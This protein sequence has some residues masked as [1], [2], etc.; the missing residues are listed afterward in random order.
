MNDAG[1]RIHTIWVAMVTLLLLMGCAAGQKNRTAEVPKWIS[2]LPVDGQYFYAIGISGRTR[3]V[4]DAWTQAANRARAELGRTIVSHVSSKDLIVSTTRGEYS[5]QL[6]DILSDTELNYTE[7]VKRWYDQY[8]NY[9]PPDHYY[10][11][12]RMS[13][14]TAATVLKS[15]N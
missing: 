10:V 15:L 5:R 1:F 4:K 13:K 8:G 7:T 11:L 2:S 6:I 9:G 12:I 14:K 3:S